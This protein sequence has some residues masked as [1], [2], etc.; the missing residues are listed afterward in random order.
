[1]AIS[2]LLKINGQDYTTK[3][4]TPFTVVRKRRMAEDLGEVMS[5]EIKG[6]LIGIFTDLEVIFYP[7][8][9]VELSSLLEILDTSEQE[10]QYYDAR[11]RTLKTLGT[12]TSD[13]SYQYRS[14]TH[15]AISSIT[16][17]FAARKR[18]FLNV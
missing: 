17:T 14:T 2:T 8:T 13:Y 9:D 5:G 18:E 1:M 16:V 7:K 6:T 3:I 11:S 12:F 15:Y 4:L 10:I